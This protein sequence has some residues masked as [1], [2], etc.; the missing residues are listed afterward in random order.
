MYTIVIHTS[1]DDD[2]D[3]E[4][5]FT[6]YI[7]ILSY[8]TDDDEI[9]AHACHDRV[10]FLFRDEALGTLTP[11]S[12]TLTRQRMYAGARLVIDVK[13]NDNNRRT[14]HGDTDRRI[15]ASAITEQRVTRSMRFYYFYIQE[16]GTL[17]SFMVHFTRA[18]FFRLA[19]DRKSFI[20][21]PRCLYAYIKRAICFYT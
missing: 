12:V 5:F 18:R 17:N 21:C 11:F 6:H 2:D 9:N 13:K 3:D 1:D 4:V 10:F 15:V 8:D 20:N 14:P 16:T 7:I 19:D